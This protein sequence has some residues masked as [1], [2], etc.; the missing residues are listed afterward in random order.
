M[1]TLL[2]KYYDTTSQYI[3]LRGLHGPLLHS[4]RT[5]ALLP[6]FLRDTLYPSTY[7][8]ISEKAIHYSPKDIYSSPLES[9]NFVNFTEE[10]Y[11]KLLAESESEINSKTHEIVKATRSGFKEYFLRVANK[12]LNACLS[13]ENFSFMAQNGKGLCY[14]DDILHQND[15][16]NEMK[17]DC[18]I[19][20]M[21]GGIPAKWPEGLKDF[22]AELNKTP[23]MAFYNESEPILEEFIQSIKAAIDSLLKHNR[24]PDFLD[25]LFLELQVLLGVVLR[26]GN[27]TQ[28]A[29][30][31]EFMIILETKIS[32]E[33]SEKLATR[34]SKYFLDLLT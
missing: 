15:F 10:A 34:I 24:K 6:P 20:S 3:D 27:Y 19:E 2:I 17:S 9:F 32:R 16:L 25:L 31:V 4:P 23:I 18:R 13:Y 33:E 21:K 14:V 5:L 28:I 12:T 29:S 11:N 22:C 1:T 8:D 26:T 7:P 30:M